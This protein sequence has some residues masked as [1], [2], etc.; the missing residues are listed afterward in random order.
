MDM[1]LR[2]GDP[3]LPGERLLFKKMTLLSRQCEGIRSIVLI[4]SAITRSVVS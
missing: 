3:T 1:D 2:L 4:S